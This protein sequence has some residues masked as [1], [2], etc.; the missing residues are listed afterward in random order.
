MLHRVRRPTLALGACA[1]LLAYAVAAADSTRG[2][3]FVDVQGTRLYYEECGSGQEVVILIHDG[4]VNSAVW[5][6][7]LEKHPAHGGKGPCADGRL[8]NV[9]GDHA[10]GERVEP[11]AARLGELLRSRDH[12]PRLPSARQLHRRAVTSVV[13]HQAQS[14]TPRGRELS[15][16]APLRV[17]PS[18]TADRAWASRVVGEGVMSCPRA[19]CGRSA[20]P[21]R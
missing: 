9:A 16:P 2:G 7:V 21:V 4:V 10:A 1:L 17:L 12:Q 13:A 5:D 14:Q 20:C 15:T 3:S 11:L 6:D 8:H 19:G 18:R